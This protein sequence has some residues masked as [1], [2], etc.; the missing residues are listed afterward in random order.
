MFRRKKNMR[1]LELSADEKRLLIQAMINF[2]NK[3]IIQ[4]KPTEDLNEILL[5][6]L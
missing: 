1:V 5:R 4:N 6:L 3:L 2:R